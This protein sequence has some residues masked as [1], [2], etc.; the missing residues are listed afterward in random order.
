MAQEQRTND[1]GA[2]PI[3]FE[4]PRVAASAVANQKLFQWVNNQDFYSLVPSIYHPFYNNW[5][6]TWLYWYDGYV[7]WIHGGAQGI[8]ST[9]IGTMIVN[10][11]SDSVFGGNLMFSNSRK[12][13]IRVKKEDSKDVGAALDFI[14][15]NW[16]KQTDFR[17]RIKRAIRYAFAGGFS[18]LKL[19]NSA[20]ELWLDSLRADR[21][22]VDLDGRGKLRKVVS[23]AS[24]YERATPNKSGNTLRYV[25]CEERR[26]ERI[27]F[28]GQEIPVVEYKS[29]E[30]TAPINYFSITDNC[31]RW[32]DLTKEVRQAFKREYEGEI[33]VPKALNCFEDLGCYLV[34]GS[35]DVSNVPQIG[36]GESLLANIMTYLYEYDFYNTC[37]N[38]DMY[39]AR[40]RVLVPKGMRSPQSIAKANGVMA[41]YGTGQN[42]GLDS[43]LY[44]KVDSTNPDAQKPEAIQFELRATEWKEARNLLLE[45]IATSIGISVSTLASYLN[46]GS[47]R[48]AREVSAEE[49]ATTLFVENARRRFE[50]PINELLKTVL[51]FY[52]YIDD[53]E[54]RWS[55]AGMT[56]VT[57]L[58]DTLT[59]AVQ[60]GLISQEAAHSAYNYDN[61]EEQNAEDYAKVLEDRK[62]Q[63][64]T[65][66]G[67]DIV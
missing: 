22:F 3:N 4:Q 61:D 27:G 35:E 24:V 11:V 33:N 26:Y 31:M 48:T 67:G 28:L 1:N 41:Q 66:F 30:T 17:T 59:K 29:Y 25:L 34:R 45:S 40:G 57:V 18:L 52:G 64:N 53:V 62:S 6:R 60:G 16:T 21:F 42:V 49:S 8:L 63:Q 43:F 54:V 55:R 2:L 37:F 44:T 38:T 39:L 12:P 51:R 23:I 7:P 36:L 47:N 56:N 58:V 9:G 13:K 5:V 65:L 10:R 46:D 20:G 14:T 32:E 50:V 19:N 15:N